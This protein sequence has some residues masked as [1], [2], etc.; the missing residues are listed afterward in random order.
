MKKTIVS[1]NMDDDILAEID[2]KKGDYFSR[3]GY[4][5]MLLREK[6]LK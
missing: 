4:L 6:L 3:S 5:N 1:I 2:K